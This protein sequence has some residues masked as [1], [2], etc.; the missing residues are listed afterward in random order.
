[1]CQGLGWG[2]CLRLKGNLVVGDRGKKTKTGAL[3][4]GQ[5]F[6]LYCVQLTAKKATT[7]IGIIRD[8]GHDEAWIIAMSNKPGYA[9][10]LDYPKQWGIDIDQSLCLSR[11]KRWVVWTGCAT[12]PVKLDCRGNP[13]VAERRVSTSFECKCASEVST[14]CALI[15]GNSSRD[16]L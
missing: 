4:E 1:M 6:P 8:P 16:V 2:Y 3:A 14:S 15:A 9:K 13:I 7:N 5:V 10:T 11:I 12:F